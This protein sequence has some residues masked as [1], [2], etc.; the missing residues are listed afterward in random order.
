MAR[1]AG[2]R[3][4]V[5]VAVRQE[6]GHV[7]LYLLDVVDELDASVDSEGNIHLEVRGWGTVT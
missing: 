3:V 7:V 4:T 1:W 2:E 5:R 6:S